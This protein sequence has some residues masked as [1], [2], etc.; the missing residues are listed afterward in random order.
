[1]TE[2]YVGPL[3]LMRMVH[4]DAQELDQMAAE[5]GIVSVEEFSESI[6]KLD[7]NH[8]LLGEE[9]V[10]YG[11]PL[12]LSMNEEGEYIPLAYAQHLGAFCAD[13]ARGTKGIYGGFTVV[14]VYYP[15]T[16]ET[17][18]RVVHM[19]VTDTVQ[20]MEGYSQYHQIKMHSYFELSDSE[21]VPVL[22]INMHSLQELN[23]DEV[24]RAFEDILQEKE[25]STLEIV[26]A[27]G[28]V[29]N[30]AFMNEEEQFERNLQRVSYL[31][32]LNMLQDVL[33]A[34][35]DFVL[36]DGDTLWSGD[37]VFSATRPLAIGPMIFDIGPGYMRMSNG[38]ILPGGPPELYA[39][40]IESM[41]KVVM[42]PI[43]NVIGVVQ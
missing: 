13:A 27:L 2:R 34:A 25:K 42:M 19:L 9:V 28:A 6:Q 1:M 41:K 35:R 16:D 30:A 23:D 14:P 22:P 18:Q 26:R 12:T 4:E 15:A 8:P 29:A 3:D 32:S 37:M 7:N 17:V 43:K 10:I 5:Q 31:N 24:I 20:Y 38:D 33:V 39:R 40:S 11:D 21:I 36:L